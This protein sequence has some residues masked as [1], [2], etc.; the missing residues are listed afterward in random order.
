MAVLAVGVLASGC[1]HGAKK[2]ER[3]SSDPKARAAVDTTTATIAAADAHLAK[4]LAEIQQGHLV[5]A[6]AEFDRAVDAYLSAP[7]G[8]LS[9]PRMAEAYT[10]TLETIR[11]H[12]MDA[13]ADGDGFAETEQDPAS[14][15]QLGD[16]A[17]PGEPSL[18]ARRLAEEAL[19]GASTPT[20]LTIDLN[21][22]V[23]SCV[24]L[25]QG[26][27]HDWFEAALE[28][29]GRYLPE[30][31]RVFAEEGI[32]QDLAY[33]ALVES[34]FKTNALSSAKAKGIFQFI[35]STGKRFG[36]RQ[37]WWVDER[38]NP[39]KATR[40]AAQYLKE[41]HEIFQD[42]NLA[43]AAYNAGEGRVARALERTGAADF[44]TLAQVSNLARETKNYVPMIHAAIVVAKAPER[45]GFSVSPEPPLTYEAVPVKGAV[46]LRVVAECT[47][48]DLADVRELNPEL[49]R[50]ATPAGRVFDV[51]VPT[52]RQGA[53]RTCLATLPSEKRVAFR[54]HVVGR[55][56]TLSGVAR[57]YGTKASD[58]AEANG[59]GRGKKLARGTE[60]IIPVKAGAAP[61]TGGTRTVRAKHRVRPG[62]TLTAIASRYNTTVRD[63]MEW[64]KLRGTALA[65]GDLL[66]IY[67][68]R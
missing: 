42:W 48:T 3:R 5:T 23:L 17:V 25:Y 62:D 33:L 18:D 2:A 61:A 39:E 7:G 59:L 63:L 26:P 28:R 13:L 64:N 35:P 44:W 57:Q 40:A 29:G 12:E 6:R 37:D 11:A 14:I 54:T 46:D 27:L 16:L 50:L 58:I 34:A 31:R 4:G 8:A 1:A 22:K 47:G 19:R 66:T 52:G 56:Q 9:N 60:L 24:D 20:D 41:L 10:R 49:R 43:M 32:P 21:D 38:S 15:D 51:K 55:G 45:Y 68:V 67:T 30:I 65:A 53:L 36:L